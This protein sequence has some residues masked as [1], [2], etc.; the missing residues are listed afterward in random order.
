VFASEN[1]LFAKKHCIVRDPISKKLTKH[2]TFGFSGSALR[3]LP[4]QGLYRRRKLCISV[5][6]GLSSLVR[7][8]CTSFAGIMEK[9]TALSW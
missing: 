9:G 7:V 1:P 6:K 2:A 5:K 3:V 4:F 8:G